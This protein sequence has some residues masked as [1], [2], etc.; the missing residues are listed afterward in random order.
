M[1]SGSASAATGAITRFK[2]LGRGNCKNVKVA[3]AQD[4]YTL[5][6]EFLASQFCQA[7]CV[8]MCCTRKCLQRTS[9]M[10]EYV[11]DLVEA[12]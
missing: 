1:K 4:G 8:V 12:G 5:L 6:V 9:R 3:V 7:A 2:N 10:W 11:L